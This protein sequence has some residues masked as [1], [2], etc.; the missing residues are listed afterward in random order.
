MRDLV[1]REGQD[2]AAGIAS[3]ETRAANSYLPTGSLSNVT[4]S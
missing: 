3:L 2:K 1:T 4:V